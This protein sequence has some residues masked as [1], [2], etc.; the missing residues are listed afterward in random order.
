MILCVVS[1]WWGSRFVGWSWMRGGFVLRVYGMT[2]ILYICDVSTVAVGVSSVCHDLGATVR[3][4]HSVL[5]RGFIVVSV[6]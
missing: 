1:G 4:I 5:S 3:E 6:F 2:F